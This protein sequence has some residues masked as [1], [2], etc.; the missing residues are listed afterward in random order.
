MAVPPSDRLK[1]LPFPKRRRRKKLATSPTKTISLRYLQR[2]IQLYL[3][4][5]NLQHSQQHNLIAAIFL[6]VVLLYLFYYCWIL[7]Q[8]LAEP[9]HFFHASRA[10]HFFRPSATNF[11]IVFPTSKRATTT[12]TQYVVTPT[13][14]LSQLHDFTASEPDYGGLEELLFLQEEGAIRNIWWDEHEHETDYRHPTAPADD[15][16]PAYVVPKETQNDNLDCLLLLTTLCML[17]T[18]HFRYFAFDDDVKKDEFGADEKDQEATC[19]RVKE[20]RLSFPTCNT[21]HEISFIESR[22]KY[23]NAG[24]YRQVMVADHNYENSKEKIILKDIHYNFEATLENYEFVRMDAIVAERLTASPRIYD[25]YG[26]CGLGIVSEFFPHGDMEAIAMPEF[27]E[28]LPGYDPKNNFTPVEK[29][30]VAK[31]MADALADLH[32]NVG[33]V[34][35]HQDVQLSQYLWNAD[36]TMV[37]L[38]DFNRAEFMLFDEHENQYCGYWEGRGQGTWRSAEEYFDKP[39]TEQVDVYSLGNNFFGILT[40]IEPFYMERQETEDAKEVIE[41]VQER[42]KNAIKPRIDP[43][44]KEHSF[45]E[46]KLVELIDW[47]LEYNPGDRPTMFQIVDYLGDAIREAKAKG[48]V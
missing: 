25:I 18:F 35:V 45:A 21:Y 40:G 15:D 26:L 13:I 9:Q 38:N 2:R 29:L 7:R 20:H 37:K 23:L 22:A 34:I 19:R 47:C 46:Q 3:R 31:Q 17:L 24:A 10:F 41:Y 1:Q 11:E 32:G 33:G 6:V 43:A 44:Y 12:T 48:E 28:V 39:L 42:V 16:I 5:N 4:Q 14:D 30:V 27:E 8:T 36:R